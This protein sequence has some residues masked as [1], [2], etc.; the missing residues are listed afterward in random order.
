MRLYDRLDSI[1]YVD[2]KIS[3]PLSVGARATSPTDDSAP[4][5][6]IRL[7]AKG[8][9]FRIPVPIDIEEL[10]KAVKVDWG[11]RLPCAHAEL[12]VYECEEEIACDMIHILASKL[13]LR[14]VASVAEFAEP[15]TSE[16]KPLIA[17]LP[18]AAAIPPVTFAD[19]E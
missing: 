13:P 17:V 1:S 2:G 9:S 11:D 5:S 3:V 15:A 14:Q 10:C 4:S 18:P 8:R 7:R 12:I 6:A 16:D 19:G